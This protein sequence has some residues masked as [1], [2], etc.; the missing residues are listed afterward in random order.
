LFV[1]NFHPSHGKLGLKVQTMW[2]PHYNENKKFPNAIGQMANTKPT[3]LNPA[4]K[5][6]NQTSINDSPNHDDLRSL[7]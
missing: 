4:A 5:I 2:V 6:Q 7:N 1:T 3:T